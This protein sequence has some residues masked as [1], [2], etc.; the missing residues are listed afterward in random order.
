MDRAVAHLCALV[1]APSDARRCDDARQRLANA[2][3]R[4]R[5][6]CGACTN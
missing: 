1:D 2:R 5:E 6:T 4:V 3:R